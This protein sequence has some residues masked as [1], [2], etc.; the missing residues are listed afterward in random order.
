MEVEG[1]ALVGIGMLTFF[2]F[3]LLG[4]IYDFWLKIWIIWALHRLGYSCWV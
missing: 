2:V 1:G 4:K 3:V